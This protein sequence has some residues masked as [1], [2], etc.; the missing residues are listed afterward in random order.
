MDPMMLD[1][2]DFVAQLLV[3]RGNLLQQRRGLRKMFA[4]RIR[5]CAGAPQKHSTIP[6]IISRSDE[7]RRS[8]QSRFL[9]K[10][11]HAQC[12]AKSASRLNIAISRLCP[13]G[14]DA[15]DYN[16]FTCRR[17]FYATLN[18]RPVTFLVTDHMVG[19]EH[20]DHRIG[21]LA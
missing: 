17:N 3:D 8:L 11:T 7:R 2:R 1:R 16:V 20:S 4:Q 5:Q 10:A 14:P 6:E 13:I 21:M 15:K 9:G 19:R 12:L 18:R